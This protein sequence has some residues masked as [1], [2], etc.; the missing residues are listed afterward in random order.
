MGE[1]LRIS[2]KDGNFVSTCVVE[3]TAL[4]S[5]ASRREGVAPGDIRVGTR[6]SHN[7]SE[8][9]ANLL[10][11]DSTELRFRRS[12]AR[13]DLDRDFIE[14]ASRGD[15]PEQNKEAEAV[16]KQRR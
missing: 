3:S 5:K 8:K 15:V 13:R 9:L 2:K 4:A 7:T 10:A 14:I 1:G 11:M 12:P 16:G 6:R